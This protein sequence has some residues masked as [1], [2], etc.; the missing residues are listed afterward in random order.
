MQKPDRF[1]HF[2]SISELNRFLQVPEPRHPLVSV[3]PDHTNFYALRPREAV[4]YRFGFYTISCKQLKGQLKYGR[5]H[6]DFSGGSLLFTAP[7]QLI[8]TGPDAVVDEGWAL[9]I[10]PDL[11]YGTPLAKRMQDYHF[12]HYEVNEALHVS[13]EEKALLKDCIDKIDRECRLGTDKHTQ[14]LLVTNIELLLNYCDRFYDRQFYT[15][16]KV[17]ADVIQRFE[18]LL[19]AYFAEETLIDKGLPNVSYFA[20]QLHLSPN[21][22]ADLLQRFTGKTTIEHI[23]LEMIDRAKDLLWGSPET[24]SE[25]AYRLGFEHPSHFARVFRAKTGHSPTSYRQL[26]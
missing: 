20:D 25:I 17:N 13:D 7:N 18:Q 9:F 24:V 4:V 22:L 3:I 14:R 21:Y 26:N 1:H 11:L 23:H 8:S 2:E 6:Y 19:K 5:G 15:R 12:F 10:H 16:A